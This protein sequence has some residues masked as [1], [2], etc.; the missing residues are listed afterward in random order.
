M[1]WTSNKSK[2]NRYQG[3]TAL[4]SKGTGRAA[5]RT[6]VVIVTKSTTAIKN[7]GLQA[8]NKKALEHS[9]YPKNPEPAL[10][11]WRQ[12][13]SSRSACNIRDYLKT[14]KNPKHLIRISTEFV[15]FIFV[16]EII[17]KGLINARHSTT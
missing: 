12:K 17:P 2:L 4:T 11:K 3:V 5:S 16:L 13:G 7:T 9:Q 8:V 6:S 15:L 14:T 10:D 1:L